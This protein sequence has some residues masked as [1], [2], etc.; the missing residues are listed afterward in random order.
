[1][2]YIR[3]GLTDPDLG[4]RRI[5]CNVA[6]RS[7]N[8]DFLKPILE[9][10]AAEHHE[11]LIREA[12]TA[13]QSLGGGLELFNVCAERVSDEHLYQIA[14]DNLQT[15]FVLPTGGHSGR[16]DLTST[17]LLELRKAWQRFLARHGEQ[18]R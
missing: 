6:A 1:M 9:I 5:A 10:I 7:G 17:E 8:R 3:R 18:I 15:V 4:V 11:W 13:A 2:K 14:L 16:S 12:G